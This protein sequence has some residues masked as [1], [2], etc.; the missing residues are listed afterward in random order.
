MCYFPGPTWQAAQQACCGLEGA[1]VISIF[2]KGPALSHPESLA[3][4]ASFLSLSLRPWAEGFLLHASGDLLK[5]KTKGNSADSTL[6]P[7]YFSTPEALLSCSF[8]NPRP[9]KLL[10]H[11]MWGSLGSEKWLPHL[12]L[13][14][15]PST[16]VGKMEQGEVVLSLVSDSCLQQAGGEASSFPVCSFNQ[17]LWH[18]AVQLAVTQ[19]SW[20]LDNNIEQNS[21]IYNLKYHKKRT[22]GASQDIKYFPFNFSWIPVCICLT[23]VAGQTELTEGQEYDYCHTGRLAQH[24]M[25]LLSFL[26]H[27]Q[28]L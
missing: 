13:S 25:P 14:T 16:C 21:L 2:M 9:I 23:V 22:F 18:L 8:P 20:A 28:N 17:W 12:C 6:S 5:G 27:N 26:F 10:E 19:L 4:A 7:K 24:L 3:Q 1:A 11:F 15:W